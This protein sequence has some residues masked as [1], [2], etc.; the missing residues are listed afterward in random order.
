[1]TTI[2]AA[3][4]LYTTALLPSPPALIARHATP[5]QLNAP[6][7]VA[8]ATDE[9]QEPWSTTDTAVNAGL[10]LLLHT[11]TWST[12]QLAGFSPGNG[13]ERAAFATA[14]LASIGAFV[15][16][17]SAAP[18]G[19]PLDDWLAKPSQPSSLP[20]L[21][22]AAPAIYAC[23]FAFASL[24]SSTIFAAI[25]TGG[26]PIELA[27]AFLPAGKA[28]EAGRAV[29]LL[30]AAPIQEELFFRAWLLGVLRR[31]NVPD[32]AALAVSAVLFAAWHLD[33]I[34]GNALAQGG[35]GGGLLQLALLG[36]FLGVL[37]S[38]SGRD[39]TLP[40]TTHAAYNGV[41]LLLGAVR[42]L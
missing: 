30:V 13:V 31:V 24:A 4:V 39:I 35:D 33:A 18:G 17:Q 12:A 21:G 27:G 8:C 16:V 41:V 22:A 29:D 26:N 1:M 36:A 19:L 15:G 28:I 10:F 42:A 3:T 23:A 32:V 25:V 5:V 7:I 14:R 2:F 37:Y 38:K 40:I 20:P 9:K 11:M 34:N 6:R